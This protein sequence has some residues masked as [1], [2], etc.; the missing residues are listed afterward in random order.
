LTAARRVAHPSSGSLSYAALK[1][2]A[3]MKKLTFALGVFA[4][5]AFGASWTGVISESKCGAAHV[6]GSEKSVNCIKACVKNGAKPVFVVDGKVL[7]IKETDKV[8][9]HLGHKVKIDGKLEGDTVSIDKIEMA[10]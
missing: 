9:E 5:S 4:M 6:D 8:M 3:A 7:K 2:I 1:E 10:H